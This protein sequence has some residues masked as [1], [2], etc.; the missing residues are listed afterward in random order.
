MMHTRRSGT[1]ITAIQHM[2]REPKRLLSRNAASS[3][4]LALVALACVGSALAQT[5][6]A[7]GDAAG[8]PAA[9]VAPAD[10]PFGAAP[11]GSPTETRTDALAL[12]VTE[13]IGETD[14]VFLTPN[15][16]QSQT[17]SNTEIDFGY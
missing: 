7:A 11:G 15:D 17:L 5:V 13:G 2:G 14:N 4:A 16:K 12:G 1:P 3:A 10:T 9:P 8:A 6:P